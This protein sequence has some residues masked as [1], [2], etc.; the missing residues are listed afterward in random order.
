MTPMKHMRVVENKRTLSVSD[1]II[2]GVEDVRENPPILRPPLR[3]L[4]RIRSVYSNNQTTL[5]STYYITTEAN[6]TA[7]LC[8]H[9]AAAEQIAFCNVLFGCILPESW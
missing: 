4:R 9:E 5:Q 6:S 1:E 8:G 2:I 7:S 3:A